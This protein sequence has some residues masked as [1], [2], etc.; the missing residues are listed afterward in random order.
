MVRWAFRSL[1][2]WAKQRGYRVSWAPP[3]LTAN[4]GAELA[5]DLEYVIAHLMLASPSVFFVQIGANDGIS[6]DP[7]YKF[8]VRFGWEGIL[9]EPVPEAFELLKSTYRGHP[10]LRLLDAAISEQD[11]SRTI[12][13]MRMDGAAFRKGHQFSSFRK[14]SLLA[15]TRWVPDIAERI[16]ERE[17]RCISFDTLLKE[18]NGR[19]VDIL[20]IDTEGY[21]FAVL[22]MIDF[23]RLRPPIICYEH[24]L[25]SKAE[26]EESARL[27][28]GHG[29]RLTRDNL[30]TI[31]YR[32]RETLGFRSARPS[33]ARRSGLNAS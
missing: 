30:D 2:A 20:Q 25:M 21:D 19:E 14:E 31:A 15:Q 32:P 27:L 24:V 11:G 12:Y 23:S 6:N 29:Y 28:C 26:Q 5:F 7:L 10:K 22:K 33:P 17:V 9:L 8:V 18:A 3:T 13:T 4:P 16:E 1:E